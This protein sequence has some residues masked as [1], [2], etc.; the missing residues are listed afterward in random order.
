MVHHFNA[1]HS[2]EIGNHLGDFLFGN[3]I[4]FFHHENEF[5]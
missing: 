5:G 3:G 4:N 1:G 2:D